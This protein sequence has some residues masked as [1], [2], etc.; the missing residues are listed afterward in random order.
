MKYCPMCGTKF[1]ANAK[2]CLECGLSIEEYKKKLDRLADGVLNPHPKSASELTPEELLKKGDIAEEEK[3][4]SKAMD[5]Y[6][7]AAELSNDSGMLRIGNMYLKGLGVEKD[8]HKALYWLQKSAEAGNFAAIFTLGYMYRYGACGL[9]RDYEK[10]V[11]LLINVAE[12]ASPNL[13]ALAHKQLMEMGDELESIKSGTKTFNQS[14]QN[15][16]SNTGDGHFKDTRLSDACEEIAK[17]LAEGPAIR[18]VYYLKQSSKAD[19]KISSA[20]KAYGGMMN[21]NEMAFACFDSTV[22]GS[23]D[24]GCIFTNRGIYVR[25]TSVDD[26]V[27][28]VEYKDIYN[29]A[30][31]G[32]FMKDIYVND[33]KIETA[34]IGE[35][36]TKLFYDLI[37][38]LH[39]LFT[40]EVNRR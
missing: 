23:A 4:Y 32:V 10:A 19:S 38:F 2:F 35:E 15:L 3:D 26:K 13:R 9:K 37:K 33:I 40:T 18:G 31:K 34:G 39:E 28:F 21:R 8:D 20:V 30:I 14:Q 11:N 29:I 22:F 36:H 1:A 5:F 16:N 24:E 6:K 27:R 25:T 7:Q 12:N 17:Y